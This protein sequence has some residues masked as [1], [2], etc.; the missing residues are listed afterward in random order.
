[1]KAH[2]F[3]RNQVGPAKGKSVETTVCNVEEVDLFVEGLEDVIAPRLAANHNETMVSDDEEINL[4]VEGPEAPGRAAN[5]NHKREKGMKE[6]DTR[7]RRNFLKVAGAGL[8]AASV[9]SIAAAALQNKQTD[10]EGPNSRPKPVYLYGCG[11]NRALPGIFGQVCLAFE[12]RAEL[13]GTGVGTFHDDVYPEV[14]S[15]FQ[16]HSATKHGDVY[17]FEGEIIAARDPANLGRP[18]TIVAEVS[19]EGDASATITLGT[20]ATGPKLV[21]I[22]IIAVLIA[23]LVPAVQKVR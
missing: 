13:E 16:I 7:N 9:P 11:W 20:L 2:K 22:A 19:D 18:V 6:V 23:L 5:H 3:D 12:M 21:V 14:N 4:E 8:V 15:Q 1:M 10:G 17:T